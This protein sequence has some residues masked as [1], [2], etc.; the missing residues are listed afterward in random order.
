MKKN[1]LLIGG[2]SGIGYQISE[3]LSDDHNIIVAS[4]NEGELDTDKIKHIKFDV[5][6]DDISSLDLPD[7]IDGLVYCPGSIDL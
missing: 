3:L 7:Q 4:R 1:I 6:K 5:L 2:S